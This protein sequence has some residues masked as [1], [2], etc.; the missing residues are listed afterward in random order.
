MEKHVSMN[1]R[2]ILM[3]G[4]GGIGPAVL[5]LILRHIDIKPEQINIL[6]ADNRNQNLAER[7]GVKFEQLTLDE[8][9]YKDLLT[10]RLEK[11]DVLLNLAVDVNSL[12]LIQLCQKLGVVYVDTSIERWKSQKHIPAM[13]YERRELVMKHQEQFK[14]GPTALL[15][16]GANPGFVSHLAKQAVLDIA[17]KE[18]GADFPEPTTR[19]AWAALAKELEVVAMHV[20]ERDTQLTSKPRGADEYVNTWSVD[21]FLEEASEF[22]G[23]SW[24]THEVDLPKHLVRMREDTDRCRAIELSKMGGEIEIKS[25]VPSG[26]YHG[27]VIPHTEAFS[28]AE[29]FN[30]KDD[31]N[32]YHPTVHYVYRPCDEAAKSMLDALDKNII[33]PEHK[34]LLLDDVTEGMDEL[35]VLILR[36]NNPEVYWLGSRLGVDEARSLVKNNNATSLQVAIGVLSGLILA[37]ANPME[38][39]I[40]AEGLDFKRAIEIAKPY[41]GDFR[42]HFAT[43]PEAQAPSWTFAELAVG[44]D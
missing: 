10:Q 12:D 3:V 7:E 9:N 23:F 37:I 41:L 32:F 28:L 34:R 29:Y 21:G 33:Y 44:L 17:R 4:F 1:G 5:P 24:G 36:A 18:K 39:L 19:E 40:E 2:K 15:C 8:H 11:G 38:G 43:W 16:H 14:N 35:G 13:L 26:V 25:W 31:G 20:A 6:S 42:G 30:C 22:T 27:Y